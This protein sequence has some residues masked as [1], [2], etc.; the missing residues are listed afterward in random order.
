MD[1]NGNRDPL[2]VTR[3]VTTP[4]GD[5]FGHNFI[6]TGLLMREKEYPMGRTSTSIYSLNPYPCSHGYKISEIWST[7]L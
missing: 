4:L 1:K 2:P 5:G 3:W 6:P 7:I